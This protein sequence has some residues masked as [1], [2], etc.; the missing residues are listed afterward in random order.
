MRR[1]ANGVGLVAIVVAAGTLIIACV[2]QTGEPRPAT[3][4]N[5]PS[6][7]SDALTT[8]AQSIGDLDMCELLKPAD[9]PVQ[10]GPDGRVEQESVWDGER[11]L[12]SVQLANVFDLLVAGVQRERVPFDGYEPLSGSAGDF[13]EIGGRRAWVGHV[14]SNPKA[15]IATFGAADGTLTVTLT[16]ETQRG[17]DPC[18]TVTELARTVISRAP[19]PRE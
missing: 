2:R 1:L 6:T 10:P 19:P 3:T 12:N 13:T 14:L 9:L 18:Q 15:C 5:Q 7:P 4:S 17:L 16:D 8:T 11:C